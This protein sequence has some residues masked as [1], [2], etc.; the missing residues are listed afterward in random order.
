[1]DYINRR[2]TNRKVGVE[3]LIVIE[4]IG[5]PSY[6][7]LHV[8]PGTTRSWSDGT[9]VAQAAGILGGWYVREEGTGF[10]FTVPAGTDNRRLHLYLNNYY[11]NCVLT[12]T[13]SDGALYNGETLFSEG[14]PNGHGTDRHFMI[15][16]QTTSDNETL[17]VT[18]IMID[19]FNPPTG[20]W[21]AVGV[22]T[23][24]LIAPSALD[25]DEK[26]RVLPEQFKLSQNFPNPFNPT[27]TI[28]Y[29]LP[30]DSR[31]N[32]TVYNMLGKEIYQLL[33][34]VKPAGS[35][36]IQWNGVDQD[37]NKVS[38]GIYLFQIQAGDF[39]QT[40]KMVLMK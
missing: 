30:E 4:E 3:E 22:G 11:S 37:G 39:V 40:K 32:I 5:S 17:E 18:W 23:A 31:V 36:S 38:T 12:A 13:T 2:P 34:S 14:G 19:G 7:G 10:Q 9:P 6:Q 1:M 33:S 25:V 21:P 15:D 8:G 28:K 16:F 20:L 35:H 24:E 27:T 26:S 29:M